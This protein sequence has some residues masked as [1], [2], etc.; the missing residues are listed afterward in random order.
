MDVSPIQSIFTVVT[1]H[2]F[3][4][5]YLLALV[6]VAIIAVIITSMRR[7]SLRLQDVSK[8]L[9]KGFSDAPDQD[10][11]QKPH[12]MIDS[13]LHYLSNKILLDESAS[14]VIKN[15]VSKLSERNLYNRYY[16]IESASSVMST[17][18]Q[19]FPLLGILGTILAIAGT[20]FEGGGID[21]SRLTSAFVLAMDT[22]ILGIAFSVIFMLVESLLN[23]KI[24][25]LINESID[26]KSIVSRCQ[27]G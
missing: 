6:E 14:E 23:P 17:L 20:A 5:I 13:A 1:D 8:N 15:N 9:V 12:E 11:L 25:R 22:T 10:S 4:L 19:V 26:F 2:I 16:T 18:V 24:E 21:A 27:L 7:H 3:E